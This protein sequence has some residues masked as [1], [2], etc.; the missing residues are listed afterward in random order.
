MKDSEFL[1]KYPRTKLFLEK[2]G[3]TLE[4]AYIWI[5]QELE[6]RNGEKH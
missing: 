6:K 5:E 2:T 3:M 1:S 4:E